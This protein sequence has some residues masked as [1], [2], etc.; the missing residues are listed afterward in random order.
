[1]MQNRQ[2]GLQPLDG[3]KVMVWDSSVFPCPVP[4][5]KEEN[6]GG[7]FEESIDITGTTL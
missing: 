5:A 3:A 4:L 7:P 1:M 2:F 6:V